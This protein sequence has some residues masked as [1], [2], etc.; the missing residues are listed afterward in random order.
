MTDPIT[1]AAVLADLLTARAAE[2]Q[3]D[4]AYWRPAYDL[5]AVDKTPI[6]AEIDAE[7]ERLQDV[8]CNLEEQLIK[9]PAD[10]LADVAFKVELTHK[11]WEGFYPPDEWNAAILADLAALQTRFAEAW[12]DQWV[13]KGG[14]AILCDDKVQL[15]FPTYDRSPEYEAL[16]EAQRENWSSQFDGNYYG[17]MNTLVACV[18][19]LPGGVDVIKAHMRD[20]G[21]TAI[22]RA[23]GEGAAA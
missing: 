9:T 8:R 19:L 10:G 15:G 7:I 5:N 18:K 22:Y 6:P 16:S 11:R 1:F 3:Y 17:T 23:R 12:L 13:G 21:K 20:T 2:E 4:A 14:S